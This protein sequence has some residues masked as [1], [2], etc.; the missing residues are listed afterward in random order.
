M[1]QFAINT[2]NKPIQ[3]AF[4]QKGVCAL[5]DIEG[6]RMPGSVYLHHITFSHPDLD[7]YSV[8]FTLSSS[9]LKGLVVWG[10]IFLQFAVRGYIVT[11]HDTPGE[12]KCP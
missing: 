6:L 2:K 3:F 9:Q 12:K 4:F 7:F 11:V 1:T 8:G 10:C 5:A